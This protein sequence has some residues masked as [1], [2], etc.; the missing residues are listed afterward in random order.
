MAFKVLQN[1]LSSGSHV[2]YGNESSGLL[3]K[4]I[5]KNLNVQDNP[6]GVSAFNSSYSDAGLFGAF[7]I[8]PPNVVKDVVISAVKVLKSINVTD[9]DVQRGKNILKM[10]TLLK[11]ESGDTCITSMGYRALLTNTVPSLGD[12]L[13][14]I[15]SITVDD[16][17]KVWIENIFICCIFNFFKIHG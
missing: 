9:K 6:I 16:V 15:D 1:C 14:E 10:T 7:I 2:K 5:P 17:K 12:I 8:A 4:G 11:M 13:K 3:A